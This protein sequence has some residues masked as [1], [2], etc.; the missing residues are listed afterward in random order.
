MGK[1]GTIADITKTG[2]VL[3]N[4]I[5]MVI[6]VILILIIGGAAADNSMA[7]NVTFF[8]GLFVFILFALI[9]NALAKRDIRSMAFQYV[10]ALIEISLPTLMKSAHMLAGRPHMMLNESTVFP[11]Y[12]VFIALTLL[13]N[14][15]SLTLVAGSAAVIEYAFLVCIGV[16]VLDLPVKAGDFQFGFIII[17][18]ELGKIVL[19][20]GFTLICNAI[21]KNMSSFARRAME[22]EDVAKKRAGFLEGVLASLGGMNLELSGVSATQ[23]NVCSKL[24]GV[25]QD[26]AAMSE[27]L[28]SIHE[29]QLASI[30]SIS[31]SMN[32]QSA[33]TDRIR[34]LVRSLQE[35]QRAV[36]AESAEL[37]RSIET[38]GGSSRKTGG[39]LADMND[40]MRIISQG[41]EAIASFIGVINDITDRIN[42]LSLNAAIE[43]ARAGE[44]GRGFAVVADEIGKLA[45][46]T[47]DN[48]KEISE[49]VGRIGADIGKGVQLVQTTLDAIGEV[50]A[51]IEKSGGNIESVREAMRRQ[52]EYIGAAGA[53]S[54]KLDRLSKS[55][56]TS[57]GEQQSSMEES[58]L[59]IQK[60]AELAQ[61]IAAHNQE[62]LDTADV[63]GTRAA[64]MKKLMDDILHD[65]N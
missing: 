22:Q 6:A 26:Q 24:A 10:T 63:I 58:A 43:A 49:R 16:F 48:A 12:M 53:Q 14:K 35:S 38:I 40:T 60:I 64:E 29:E 34:E 39:S 5:R 37:L 4:R 27:E 18:D 17:D 62:I 8:S 32:D 28:S 25:S 33:E 55:I 13:Q 57:T 47:S 42:L 7:I 11:A 44:H 15:R 59:S 36:L 21:L 50:L 54:K 45:L 41:G 31:L 65:E 20:V 3:A 1:T 19:L 46:A 51:L 30:E 23:R 56:L 61:N 2:I 9:N 52:D